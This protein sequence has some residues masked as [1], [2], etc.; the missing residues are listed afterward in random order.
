MS[1]MA[2]EIPRTIAEKKGSEKTRV[3]GSETT[4]AIVSVPPGNE[5]AAQP[6]WGRSRASLW[7]PLRNAGCRALLGRSYSTPARRLLSKRSESGD[8]IE[9]GA[10]LPFPA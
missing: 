5:A 1:E 2:F 6:G 9:C 7:L 4:S 8:L 10:G 3:S